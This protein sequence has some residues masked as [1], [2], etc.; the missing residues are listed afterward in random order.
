MGGEVKGML[1][2][3]TNTGTTGQSSEDPHDPKSKSH[4]GEDD[5]F[6]ENAP[7]YRSSRERSRREARAQ[8]NFTRTSDLVRL[9][10]N[11]LRA[12]TNEHISES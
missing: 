10:I 9:P 4:F 8:E 1:G 3:T 6:N 7:G 12:P 11:H 5:N 2:E